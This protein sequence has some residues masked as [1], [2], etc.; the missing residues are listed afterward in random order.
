MRVFLITG[1]LTIMAPSVGLAASCEQSFKSEGVPLLTPTVYRATQSFKGVK[2]SDALQRMAQ[3]IAAD[4]FSG[5]TINKQLASIDA[6]QDGSGSGRMQTLRVT[7]RKQGDHIRVDA[8]FT[9]KV[10]QTMS[11]S[12]AR[13]GLC[14]FIA[15]AAK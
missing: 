9:L 5:I 7:A 1:L 6:F 12:V 2:S 15:A 14:G 10:G 4:G 8:I 13:K 3:A 11:T